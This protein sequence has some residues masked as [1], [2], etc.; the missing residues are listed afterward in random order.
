M[1]CFSLPPWEGVDKKIN[2]LK[3]CS[4]GTPVSV[5]KRV[6][7]CL[8]PALLFAVPPRR[9]MATLKAKNNSIYLVGGSS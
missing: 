9:L 1:S 4:S 6:I 7:L 8:I 3:K 2:P 5:A